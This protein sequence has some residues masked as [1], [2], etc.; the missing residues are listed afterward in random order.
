[1][2]DYLDSLPDETA[3][4]KMVKDISYIHGEGGF[5]ICNWTSNSATVLDSIANETLGS[6]AVRLK[7]G[8]HQ[9]YDG[10]RTLG[11]IWFPAKDEWGFDVSL[12]R[13]PECIVNSEQKPTKRIM[14]TI[15]MSIFDVFGFL[16]PFTIQGKLM[17]QD[18]WRCNIDWDD[19]VPDDIFHKWREWLDLLK[20]IN[21][22]RIPRCY[23][24]ATTG[25]SEIDN[26]S[27]AMPAAPPST[28]ATKIPLRVAATSAP[29]ATGP[30]ATLA[31]TTDYNNNYNNLQ[32]HLFSDSSTKAMCAVAYW[33]WESGSKICVAFVASKSRVA[34]VKP[35]TV[36]RLELQA[37]LLA[38]RLAHSLQRTHRVVA[39]RRFFWC[40]STTVLHWI[41]ND[42]RNYKTFVANR[43]GEI[44]ELSNAAEWRYIPTKL[45]VADAATREVYDST[46]F[47]NEWFKGPD[48]LHEDVSKWPRDLVNLKMENLGS[49]FVTLVQTTNEYIPIPDPSRFSSWLRLLR[50]TAAVLKFIDRCRKHRHAEIDCAMMERAEHLLLKRAQLDAFS[51]EIAALSK[52]EAIDRGSR[53]VKLS[54]YL[55]RG[56]LRCGGRIDAARGV[57][58]RS[59]RPV[60]LDGAHAL[61]RLL[62]RSY[63]ERAAHSNQETVVNELKQKYYLLR[64][65][66]TVKSVVSRCMLCRIRKAKP[67]VPKMGDLPA[68][69]LAHHQR[70]FTFCGLDLFGPMAVTVGRRHESR[71]GLLFTCLTVRA[72]HLE[73]VHSL[74]TDSL[75]M[76]LRRMA[77]RR[78]WPQRLYSDNG[79]NLR[80]AD[81]ELKRSL[82]E[83]DEDTLRN[84]GLNHG[85]QWTFI[86][87][88]S[89][90]WGG[91]WER[92]IR[93]VK[94]SLKVVLKERAPKDEVLSTLMAEVENIINGRPLTHVSV[95]PESE[96][97]LTPN[98]FLLGSSS[99][100]PVAGS[101]DDSEI[102]SSEAVAQIAEVSGHVLVA[103]DP[104]AQ[105]NVWQKGLIQQV[106]PGR[107]GRIRVVEVRTRSGMLKRPAAR[108]ARIP[109]SNE[110]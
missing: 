75:I 108:V 77:A 31:T 66:P 27:V 34:P 24:H 110:C 16:A 102:L 37:A 32:L 50:A 44:D 13:V 42:A 28:S 38:A 103:L 73:L 57:P 25:A 23:L 21:Y 86:P 60:V 92:L 1:M 100:L 17:L 48:F 18:A 97:T 104:A 29:A 7:L 33:R 52:G 61:T 12:K 2:D 85:V 98:H 20:V 53:L 56:L 41:K 22:I 30:N 5:Q 10:E 39:A 6:T 68:A 54:P 9:Q 84:E 105:R 82:Q 35:V 106:F 69:R 46:I 91:A 81:A 49:E 59:K 64:L 72:I 90:H 11:L 79:T 26:A 107:D 45:N 55:E 83:L 80:G 94:V 40:D 88:Q 93:S 67:Q 4:I 99:N 89:P 51:P 43:L 87:P 71:Y 63:H 74:T 65:R 109:L 15:V 101:F 36:P 47:K 96:E 95:D 14:L 8:E 19:F 70:P 62:V 78:G 3:A 58:A 76:A